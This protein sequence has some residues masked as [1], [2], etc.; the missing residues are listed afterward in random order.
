VASGKATCSCGATVE[1]SSSYDAEVNHV[2]K[3]FWET[4]GPCLATT[5]ASSAPTS[6]T[7]AGKPSGSSMA[8]PLAALTGSQLEELEQYLAADI[9]AFSNSAHLG[10]TSSVINRLSSLAR[11]SIFEWLMASGSKT[12]GD[13]AASGV[14]LK[15]D[16]E[17]R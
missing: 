13:L 11:R 16:G 14:A 5:P 17:T 1:K 10:L 7:P 3:K 15:P 6:E 9:L 4:H 12:D 8:Q 2:L